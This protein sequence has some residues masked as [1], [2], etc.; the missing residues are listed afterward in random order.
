MK[1]PK[2][3]RTDI[4]SALSKTTTDVENLLWWS[5]DEL[6]AEL[7][8]RATIADDFDALPNSYYGQFKRIRDNLEEYYFEYYLLGDSDDS[9][10]KG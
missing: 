4:I 2:Q 8:T 3:L 7:N 1:M 5:D 9:V 10:S 6:M